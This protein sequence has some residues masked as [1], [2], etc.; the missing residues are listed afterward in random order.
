MHARLTKLEQDLAAALR[1]F[2][3][4]FEQTTDPGESDLDNEQ[5][6]HVT[7]QL[8]DCRAAARVLHRANVLA[9]AGR[10]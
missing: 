2:V 1:P 8:G 5:P 7:V 4:A 10:N 6:R 9:A 3:D